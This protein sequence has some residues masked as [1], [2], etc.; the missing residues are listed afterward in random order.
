MELVIVL[1]RKAASIAANIARMLK[2]RESWRLAA[3]ASTLDAVS[4]IR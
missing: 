2:D 4:E 3:V 1:A